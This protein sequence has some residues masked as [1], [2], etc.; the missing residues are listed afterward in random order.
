MNKLKCKSN[1]QLTLDDDFNVPDI[2]PDI[3]KIIK[4]QGNIVITEVN[5]MNGKLMVKGSLQFNL[6]YI[7]EDHSRPVHNITGELPF[8]EVVNLDNACSEDD[9]IVK[10]ELEDLNTSLINSRK[11]SVKAI[12]SFQ[13]SA[14]ELYDEETAVA[15]EGDENLQYQNKRMD[16]TQLVVNKKDTMRIKDEIRIPT[17]KP[18]LFEILYHDIRLQGV[19]NRLQ[20]DKINSKGEMVLFLLY[21]SDDDA[22]SLQYFETELPFHNVIEC[23]GCKENMIPSIQIEVHNKDLQIKPDEDG[24]ERIIDLEVVLE[25]DM[26]VFEDE[27]VEVLSDLY[28]TAKEIIPIKKEAEYK[29]LILKNNSKARV[30]DHI[31][32]GAGQPKILQICSADGSLRIDE[33]QFVEDG[34]EVEGVIEV[35]LL[36]LTEEDEKP[37]GAAKAVI[38]FTQ[39]IEVKGINSNHIVELSPTMEQISTIMLDSEEVEIKIS[40]NLDLVVFDKV[41]EDIITD[42]KVEDFDLEKLQEMPSMVGYIVKNE[43]SLWNIAKRFYTTVEEIKELNELEGDSI[44]KGNKL[45][46][47]KKVDAIL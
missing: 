19:E 25:L 2:K 14:E 17:G 5:P 8:D 20:E 21:I 4:E 37:I 31:N 18:N 36:Y 16:V 33:Q 15:V 9:V 3:E 12:V 38:P 45:L 32:I 7:S 47:M 29:H 39:L 23:N 10:W 46:V 28:S 1:M 43:D 22:Q 11:I 27:E 30:S 42:L 34:I 41:K 13:C 40:L 44:A 35:Q 6:L 26:K 24:E